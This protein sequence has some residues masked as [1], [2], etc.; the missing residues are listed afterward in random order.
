MNI[1]NKNSTIVFE[2]AQDD[3]FH[4]TLGIK[5][6]FFSNP[7]KETLGVFILGFLIVLSNMAGLSGAGASAPIL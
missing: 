3:E 1:D 7:L 4:Q 6:D 2:V 5:K